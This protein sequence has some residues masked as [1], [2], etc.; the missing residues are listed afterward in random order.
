MNKPDYKKITQV[1]NYIATKEGGKINYMKAL[2]LL[3]L[4]ERLHLREYGRLI[5]DD[6]LIA[7][8]NGTLGSQAKDIATMSEYLPHVVYEYV[9]NKLIS[10]EYTIEAKSQSINELSD[11]DIECIDKILA[12]F[13]KKTQ[14]ELA[15]LTHD[16]PEWKKHQYDI[17][18]EATHV[19]ILNVL[20]LFKSTHNKVLEKI[21]SQ[22]SAELDLSRD[23]F[24]ES[25]EHKSQLA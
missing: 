2:K 6:N 25:L 19:V 1:L 3:Y 16:L 5:T 24:S 21:Y 4:S 9:K 10:K 15:E 8:K 11:T 14:Y 17:E 13:G 20:D 7:M 22:T 23:L 12:V 18:N